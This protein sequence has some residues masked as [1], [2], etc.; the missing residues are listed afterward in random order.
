LSLYLEKSLS[1]KRAGRVAPGVG[2]EFKPHTGKKKQKTKKEL[3]GS[4]QRPCSS[5]QI[6]IIMSLKF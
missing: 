1:Q 4:V 6:I 5:M 3:K 2:P